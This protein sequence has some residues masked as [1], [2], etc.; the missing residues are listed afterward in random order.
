M[1]VAVTGG[2][3]FVGAHLVARLIGARLEV[4]LVGPDTGRSPYVAALVTAGKARFI[5]CDPTFRDETVVR[6]ALAD[7]DVL[8]HLG[9]LSSGAADKHSE[10]PERNVAATTRLL[11]AAAGRV[12]HVVFASSDSVYGTPVRMPARELDPARPRTSFGLAKLACEQAVRGSCATAGVS[13]SILRYASVYGPG[14]TASRAIP[15]FI[16]AALAGEPLL[17]AGQGVD[18]GDYVHVT[19]AVTA[20]M[21]ALRRE[22]DGTYNV[23]TGIGT[24]TVELAQL[25]IW[26]SGGKARLVRG[27][28]NDGE[29]DRTSVVLD[30][31]FA[32]SAISFVAGRSLSEGLAEEIGWFKAA[33][34]SE[35]RQLPASA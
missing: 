17:V 33:A 4:S 8:V 30:P 26:I 32:R 11:R 28:S 14:E 29:R 31:G 22:A 16:R 2:G 13:A 18:E 20:T 5:P 15:R 6:S 24:T 21:N 12:R 7:A 25:V 9:H 19:D 3:G 34:A 27:A 23:G 1:R 35:P 10:E